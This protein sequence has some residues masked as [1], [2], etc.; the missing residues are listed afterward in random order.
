MIAL[1]SGWET[2]TTT[3]KRGSLAVTGSQLSSDTL[4]DY[5]DIVRVPQPG[6]EEDPLSAIQRWARL[7][8]FFEQSCFECQSPH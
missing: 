7:E 6:P 4:T 5:K 3:T 8:N 2:T 1:W